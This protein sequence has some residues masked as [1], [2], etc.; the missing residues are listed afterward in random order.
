MLRR[1]GFASILRTASADALPE[2]D[3][4][5]K[6]L[7][8]GLPPGQDLFYRIRFEDRDG[9]AGETPQSGISAPRLPT[10]ARSPSCGPAT[11]RGRAGAS[12]PRAA[13]CA[14]TAPC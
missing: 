11:P 12:M 6:L 5:A 13:A 4:T 10:A 7:L 14:A 2:R 3:L 1:R 8:D 9:V